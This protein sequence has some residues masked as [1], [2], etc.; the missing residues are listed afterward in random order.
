MRPSATREFVARLESKSSLEASP[1]YQRKK[2]NTAGWRARVRCGGSRASRHWKQAR[3]TNEII[4]KKNSRMEG[5][6]SL[7]RLESESSLE[8]GP[9]Y[10]DNQDPRWPVFFYFILFYRLLHYICVLILLYFLIEP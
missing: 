8:A 4:K 3:Y 10:H 7:R 6:S 9:I 2:K 5:E 1:I